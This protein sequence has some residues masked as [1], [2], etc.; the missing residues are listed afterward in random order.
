M[1]IFLL[2]LFSLTSV[3]VIII[4]IIISRS[5][6]LFLLVLSPLSACYCPPYLHHHF[7]SPIIQKLW[8]AGQP[9]QV[10]PEVLSWMNC[11]FLFRQVYLDARNT[12]QVFLF[13]LPL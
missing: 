10:H 5:T 7:W 11:V 1:I 4:I 13:G 6:H 2:L 9:H 8:Q 3:I 12:T